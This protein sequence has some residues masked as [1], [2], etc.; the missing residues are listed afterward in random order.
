MLFSTKLYK[1]GIKQTQKEPIE[2]TYIPDK[3]TNC[4]ESIGGPGPCG[5]KI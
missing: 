2:T 1:K 3:Y 5:N 4:S